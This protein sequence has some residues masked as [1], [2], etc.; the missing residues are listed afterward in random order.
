MCTVQYLDVWLAVI[1]QVPF[2]Q[3]INS[4]DFLFVMFRLTIDLYDQGTTFQEELWSH[5]DDGENKV[6][7]NQYYLR[8]ISQNY[9]LI[10][11][12]MR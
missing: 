10:S 3:T 6:N 8:N 5:H 12:S 11:K 1:F 4:I 7:H 9:I 2:I